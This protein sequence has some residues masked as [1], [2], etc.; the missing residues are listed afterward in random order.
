MSANID[1]SGSIRQLDRRAEPDEQVLEEH[2]QDPPRLVRLLMGLLRDVARL[3]RSW[4]PRR[5]DFE[6][7]AVDAT[8]TTKYRFAHGLDGRVRWYVVDWQG[9]AGPQLSR[10]ADTTDGALVLVSHVAG[11]ATIRVEEAG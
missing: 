1:R 3:K 2:V 9:A 4:R 5:I 10:H 8:G 7:R 6:D 11:T